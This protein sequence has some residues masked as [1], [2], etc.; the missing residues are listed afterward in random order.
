MQAWGRRSRFELRDAGTE[1]SKSGVIGLIGQALG[2]AREDDAKI[3]QLG[4]CRMGVRADREGRSVVDFHT[5]GGG[6]DEDRQV[7]GT[8]AAVL[9]QREYL[10][11]ASFLIALGYDDHALAEEIREALANPQGLLYLGRKACPVSP[12][13]WQGIVDADPETALR[14]AFWPSPDRPEEPVRLV[15]ECPYGEGEP[16]Q[17]QP[18]SFRPNDRIHLRRWVMTH[19][20][21][22]ED[23]VL[24][25]E[26]ASTPEKAPPEDEVALPA[27]GRESRERVER[28]PGPPQSVHVYFTRAFLN[29]QSKDVQKDL[30][31]IH[32]LHRRVMSGFNV[33]PG[34][35]VRARF[36]ALHRIDMDPKAGRCVLHVQSTTEPD[37]RNWPKGYVADFMGALQNPATASATIILRA[38]DDYDFL[39]RGSPAWHSGRISPTVW[40]ETMAARAG[41]ELCDVQ[42]AREPDAKGFRPNAEAEPD[43]LVYASALYSGRLRVL[44]PNALCATLLK[45]FGRGKAW[46][47]GLLTLSRPG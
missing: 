21:R 2:V 42:I 33:V 4:R 15:L 44:D 17:D 46:G 40:I 26:A 28:D 38:G 19:W 47:F 24:R 22:P 9:T 18:V 14:T 1:P 35:G 27:V 11:D 29:P 30:E 31:D 23:L 8:A 43:R 5:V 12:H 25:E 13:L 36:G 7:F 16:R 3:K 10:A 41:F 20:I 32:A 39:L 6:G 34:D 37:W 45:G